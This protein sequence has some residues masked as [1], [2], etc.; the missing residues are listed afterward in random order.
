MIYRAMLY[1]HG[2]QAEYSAQSGEKLAFPESTYKN[3]TCNTLGGATT[4]LV[5]A[6]HRISH[7]SMSGEEPIE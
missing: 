7:Q 4:R 6:C 2:T 5:R 1:I 3:I